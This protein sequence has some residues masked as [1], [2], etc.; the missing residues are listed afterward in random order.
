HQVGFVVACEAEPEI[1]DRAGA[2]NPCITGGGSNVAAR[3]LILAVGGISGGTAAF[4]VDG[5]GRIEPVV[6]SVPEEELP[7]GGKL[8]IHAAGETG[9]SAPAGLRVLKVLKQVHGGSS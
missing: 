8:V 9:P 1:D 3:E 6:P 4:A 2:G 7:P 5:R